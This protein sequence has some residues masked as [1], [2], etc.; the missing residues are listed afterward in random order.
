MSAQRVLDGEEVEEEIRDYWT[1]TAGKREA[2]DTHNN[3]VVRPV[4][5]S[6]SS[7]SSSSSSRLLS[8]ADDLAEM[9]GWLMPLTCCAEIVQLQHKMTTKDNDDDDVSSIYVE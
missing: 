6:A 4:E 8:G 3:Y 5:S 7:S 1:H 2:Q 9:L